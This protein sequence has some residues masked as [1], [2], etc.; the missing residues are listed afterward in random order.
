[1]LAASSSRLPHVAVI[2]ER[3]QP[4]FDADPLLL[5]AIEIHL[6]QARTELGACG[7]VRRLRDEGRRSGRD[8]EVLPD[9]PSSRN[10]RQPT[11]PTSA[12][13]ARACA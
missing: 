5:P 9:T 4:H 10:A 11:P 7:P 8:S 3:L 2:R 6:D 12:R 13:E 1:M